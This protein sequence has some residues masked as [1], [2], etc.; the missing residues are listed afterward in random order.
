MIDPL[1]IKYIVV[2]TNQCNYFIFEVCVR[3]AISTTGNFILDRS[4]NKTLTIMPV[5]YKTSYKA[6]EVFDTRGDAEVY[7]KTVLM[8]QFIDKRLKTL[9]IEWLI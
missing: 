3:H 2:P 4:N 9:N 6:D 8:P 5:R 1:Y 7:A